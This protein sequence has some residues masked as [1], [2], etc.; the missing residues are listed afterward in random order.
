MAVRRKKPTVKPPPPGRY[1]APT[2]Q[3]AKSSPLW[4]PSTM[5]AALLT[6]VIIIV[7]N[8]LG[9]LP[10]GEAQNS[11]LFVGLGM[12]IGGFALSTQYR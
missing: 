3:S 1:T 7:M 12:L 6:G 5:F 11:Y 9:L 2:P 8:Y 4:V 10:G